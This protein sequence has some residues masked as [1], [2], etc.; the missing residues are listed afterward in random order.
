MMQCDFWHISQKNFKEL[1]SIGITT[2][3]A[4][5]TISTKAEWPLPAYWNGSW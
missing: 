5:D 4:S 3:K 1:N 2:L